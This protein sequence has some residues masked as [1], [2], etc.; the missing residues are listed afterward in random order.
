MKRYINYFIFIALL[1]L[2]V[3]LIFPLFHNGFFSM[4]DDTQVQRVYEMAKALMD[5][6]FPVRW[7]TDLGYGYGYPMFNYYAPFIY[8][9]GA[10]ISFVGFSFITSTKIMIGIGI[11]LSGL[12]MYLLANKLFGRFAGLVA[13]VLYMYAPYH[14]LDIY[15]RGDMA[16]AFA[17]SLI[18]F[19][20]Y[21]FLLVDKRR[22]LAIL[23]GSVSYGLLII[24]H[25]L[26]AF[27]VTPI[28][29][30][31]SLYLIIKSWRRREYMNIAA[32]LAIIILG[33]LFS[34][35]YWLPA[36]TELHDT[37]VASITKGGSDFHDNFV[38]LP[39]L[40]NS[41]WGFGGSAPGCVDGL[42]FRIGKIHIVLAVLALISLFGLVFSRIRKKLLKK[43]NIG[44]IV[45]IY[46]GLI[47]SI[48][49]TLQMSVAFWDAFSFMSFFQFP[50]RFLILIIFFISLAGGLCIYI[51]EILFAG[52]KFK[53]YILSIMCLL[54][55]VVTFFTDAKLFRPQT[56]YSVTDSYYLNRTNLLWTTSKTSDEYMPQEFYKPNNKTEALRYNLISGSSQILVKNLKQSA[57]NIEFTTYS[58]KTQKILVHLAPFPGWKV[59]LNNVGIVP[60]TDVNGY[61]LSLPAGSQQV[62]FIFMSTFMENIANFISLTGIAVLIIVIITII[63]KESYADTEKKTFS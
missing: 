19:V 6:M 53:P 34:A 33:I 15:V 18:P 27:M 36:I 60:E 35:F 11:L 22:K 54:I 44:L 8:Y 63:R 43:L 46:V 40:W 59:F 51:F 23:L 24:S 26:T 50:W 7:S 5:G 13:V 20:F 37:N 62:R 1:L 47:L 49:L 3:P 39:Q 55:I 45:G 48:F 56:I 28:L 10:W 4:H 29:L 41:P 16:E 2:A 17:Y 14:A 21:S 9:L 38:C 31:I 61:L 58:L 12:G 42:S 57:N 32:I 30:L 25:N 52:I